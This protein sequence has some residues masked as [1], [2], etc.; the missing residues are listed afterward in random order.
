MPVPLHTASG[1]CLISIAELG[2]FNRERMAPKAENIHSL[3]EGFP[4]VT[5]SKS[6]SHHPSSLL[7]LPL[8]KTRST[9]P[10]EALTLTSQGQMQMNISMD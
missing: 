4:T 5:L 10:Q 6:R 9:W 8:E 2:S 1:C 3:T 7:L